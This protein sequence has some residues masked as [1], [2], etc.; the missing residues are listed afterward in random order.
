M[1]AGQESAWDTQGTGEMMMTPSRASVCI[2]TPSKRE[3]FL[4]AIS[5]VIL[6]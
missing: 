5:L 4:A 6:C 1:V 2:G 3:H